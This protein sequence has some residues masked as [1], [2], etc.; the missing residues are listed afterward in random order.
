MPAPSEL[1]PARLELFQ[2]FLHV[3][4]TKDGRTVDSLSGHLQASIQQWFRIPWHLGPGRAEEYR[5][6]GYGTQMEAIYSAIY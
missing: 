2:K 1:D 6:A 3:R 4:V 5:Y